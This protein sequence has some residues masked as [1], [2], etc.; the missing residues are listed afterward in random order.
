LKKREF[1][2]ADLAGLT[3]QDEKGKAYGKVIAVHNYG[4]GPFLEI[5][6]TPKAAFMLP[7]NK[8]CV[9][10]VNVEEGYI[11]IDPPEGWTDDQKQEKK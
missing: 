6:H 9:P 4:G 7:F 1:Y 3:A 10:E 5:G 11:V 2:E 8:I